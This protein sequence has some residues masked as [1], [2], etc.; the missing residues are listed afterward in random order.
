M[1]KRFLVLVIYCLPCLVSLLLLIEYK[2]RTNDVA[3]EIK[4]IASYIKEPERFIITVDTLENLKQVAYIEQ[5]TLND[6]L[7]N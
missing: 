2:L 1:K 6:I 5:E 7:K 3:E 4:N